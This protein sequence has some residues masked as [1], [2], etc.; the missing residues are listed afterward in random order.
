VDFDEPYDGGI[1]ITNYAFSIDDLT[2]SEVNPPITMSPLVIT[3]LTNGVTYPVRIRAINDE[4]AGDPSS[5]SVPG[6]PFANLGVIGTI[7]ASTGNAQAWIM[8]DTVPNAVRYELSLDDGPW[9]NRDQQRPMH[10]TNLTNG[11]TYT[12]RVRPIGDTGPGR[13]SNQVT[14]T[15]TGPAPIPDADITIDPPADMP[16]VAIDPEGFGELTFE[17]VLTST[18]E[19]FLANVW[20]LPNNLPTTAEI[21]RMVPERGTL[22]LLPTGQWYWEGVNLEYEGHTATILITIKDQYDAP[23]GDRRRRA[24]C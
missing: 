11:Q 16:Q 5:P 12:A 15:P 19:D 8:Y 20:L 13:A 1:P 6:T 2:W 14:F 24:P 9:Q 3:G 17:F 23:C 22:T 7:T 4:G 10:V 18:N 21:L